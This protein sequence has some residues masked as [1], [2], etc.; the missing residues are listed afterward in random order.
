[1]FASLLPTDDIMGV[2]YM[3]HDAALAVAGGP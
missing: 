1:M 2:E 3:I